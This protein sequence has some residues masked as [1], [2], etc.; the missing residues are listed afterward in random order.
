MVSV[1]L[2]PNSGSK[3]RQAQYWE[4]FGEKTHNAILAVHEDKCKREGKAFTESSRYAVADQGIQHGARVFLIVKDDHAGRMELKSVQ[5]G[6][7]SVDNVYEVRVGWYGGCTCQGYRRH[8]HC[9]HHEALAIVVDML[10]D[11]GGETEARDDQQPAKPAKVTWCRYSH[12]TQEEFDALKV[13]DFAAW[14]EHLD[15]C[16]ERFANAWAE[17]SVP[18]PVNCPF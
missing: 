16:H 7:K 5:A 2:N 13:T 6:V 9:K 12:L 18:E 4:V 14:R 11:R 1:E 10:P 3:R 17:P 8:K 15:D